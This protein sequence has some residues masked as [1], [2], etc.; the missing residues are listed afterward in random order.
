MFVLCCSILY[1]ACI[2]SCMLVL[3]WYYVDVCLYYAAMLAYNYVDM[4]YA[5]S[6][7]V[8]HATPFGG[9]DTHKG[10]AGHL[11]GCF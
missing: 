5:C 10:M 9:C 8:M 4:M 3:C 6:L 7:F 1:Y 2:M 11:G